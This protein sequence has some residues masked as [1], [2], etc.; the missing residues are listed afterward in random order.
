MTESETEKLT[1]TAAFQ[2]PPSPS[3]PHLGR[4][5][6]SLLQSEPWLKKSTLYPE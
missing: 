4:V 3:S 2:T 1:F 6:V 5:V